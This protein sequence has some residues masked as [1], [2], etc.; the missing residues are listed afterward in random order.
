MPSI[1]DV[2][3]TRYI[4]TSSFASTGAQGA[5]LAFSAACAT[6][7]ATGPNAR[8][9]NPSAAEEA[10]YT[11]RLREQQPHSAPTLSDLLARAPANADASVTVIL[12]YVSAAALCRQLRALVQQQG[13]RAEHI[14]AVALRDPDGDGG[15]EARRVVASFESLATGV[16]ISVVSSSTVA[17]NLDGGESED[18]SLA[19]RDPSAARSLG[20]LARFQLAL[21]PE[22][23][24]IRQP[25]SLILHALPVGA[26]A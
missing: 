9:T 4:A 10:E 3:E 2:E 21:Q 11:Q 14:W 13:A 19:D 22:Q 25:I 6:S 15:R 12:E 16:P 18:G 26:P 5:H 23:T 7:S 8:H 17:S 24:Y 1:A 20:R